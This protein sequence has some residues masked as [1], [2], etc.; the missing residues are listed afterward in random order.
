M[1]RAWLLTVVGAAALCTTGCGQTVPVEGAPRPDASIMSFGE[2]ARWTATIQQVNQVRFNAP[3]SARD[4]SYGSLQWTQADAPARSTVNLAF[5]YTGS[6]RELSW[7]I[8]FGKCGTAS[9]TVLPRSSFPELD[10]GG[11]GSAKVNATLTLEFP[12]NGHVPLR[13]L[14]RSHWRSRIAHRKWRPEVRRR[15][16]T[17]AVICSRR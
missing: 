10:T 9:M 14:Q 5:T 8:L 13:D 15:L 17:L 11:G 12:N 6:E 3:D 1:K 4:R 2:E 16:A 7:A